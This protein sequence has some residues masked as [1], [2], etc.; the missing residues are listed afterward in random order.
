MLWAFG[1]LLRDV[2]NKIIYIKQLI[3]PISCLK[4]YYIKKTR[5]FLVFKIFQA[6][7]SPKPGENGRETSTLRSPNA[8]T[9]IA[10][11]SATDLL[12]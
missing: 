10:F 12:G 4:Y 2:P 11:I 8:M 9:K 6:L 5:L 7:E 1:G 3:K